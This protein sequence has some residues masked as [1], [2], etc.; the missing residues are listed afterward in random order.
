[1]MGK[2]RASVVKAAVV[3]VGFVLAGVGATALAATSAIADIEHG[4]VRADFNGDGFTDLAVGVPLEDFAATDD[5]GVH[6][7]YGTA[8]G[9]RGELRQE[10]AS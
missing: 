3:S 1:M 7:I 6:V 5:G 9:L 2:L 8:N 10:C 4:G